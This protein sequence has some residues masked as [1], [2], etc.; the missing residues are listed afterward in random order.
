MLDSDVTT[1]GFS[2]FNA[3]SASLVVSGSIFGTGRYCSQDLEPEYIA[4]S[5]DG[6]TA[7]VVCQENNAWR[8]SILK[9]LP[10]PPFCHWAIRIG[11]RKDSF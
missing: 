6:A 7:Y 4:V 9:R 3:D 10:L 1:V 2:A 8:L 5:D 11:H